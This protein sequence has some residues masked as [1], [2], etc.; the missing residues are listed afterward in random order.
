MPTAIPI[1]EN[2]S[3]NARGAFLINGEPYYVP[4]PVINC[5]DEEKGYSFENP[6]DQKGCY[7]VRNDPSG[8][9]INCIVLHWDVCDSV[10]ECFRVLCQSELS[11][12]IMIDED[13]TVYQIL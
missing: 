11:A 8:N 6:V 1:M 9:G 4:F 10:R 13:G 3:E 5:E 12:H 7:G 2:D